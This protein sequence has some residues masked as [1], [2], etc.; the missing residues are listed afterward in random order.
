M[1][2]D[3]KLRKFIATTIREY[4]NEGVK[5]NSYNEYIINQIKEVGVK[6]SN[7]SHY[8]TKRPIKIKVNEYLYGHDVEYI[9]QNE[10]QII[11]K[12]IINNPIDIYIENLENKYLEI[13]DGNH[14]YLQAKYNGDKYILANIHFIQYVYDIIFHQ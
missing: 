8:A 5:Y 6:E 11:N 2:K 12:Q 3:M 13:I 4:L 14:R 10:P 9:L 7:I 1:K